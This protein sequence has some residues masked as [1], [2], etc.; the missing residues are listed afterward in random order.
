MLKYLDLHLSLLTRICERKRL[1]IDSIVAI[2]NAYCTYWINY[3]AFAVINYTNNHYKSIDS[4]TLH[5]LKSLK[6]NIML[7]G[8]TVCN[9]QFWIKCVDEL[10]NTLVNKGRF[11]L[12][13]VNSDMKEALINIEKSKISFKLLME[14]KLLHKE[15]MKSVI[16]KELMQNTIL[17]MRFKNVNMRRLIR[18]IYSNV[19]YG[20]NYIDISFDEI[21]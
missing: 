15:I 1:D 8:Y 16:E 20:E 14:H 18:E 5:R 21:D 11:K 17:T 4:Q 9:K 10:I 7:D 2:A 6:G 19:H 3:Y 12:V 13:Y